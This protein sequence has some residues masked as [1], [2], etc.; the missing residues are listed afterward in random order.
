MI[1][2]VLPYGVIKNNSQ[3]SGFCTKTNKWQSELSRRS[4]CFK[5][6]KGVRQGCLICCCHSTVILNMWWGISWWIYL[7]WC[8]DKR[9]NEKQSAVCR[10]HSTHCNIT[11]SHTDIDW[12][13]EY[14]KT[15]IPWVWIRD[16]HKETQS[17]GGFN[18]GN[19]GSSYMWQ[20][21]SY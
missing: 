13:D 2:H 1:C 17:I 6:G 4:Q 18:Q 16:Q 10:Q 11:K 14:P 3:H 19:C 7:D 8:H 21:M 9:P 5:I 12:Q 15:S 20:H